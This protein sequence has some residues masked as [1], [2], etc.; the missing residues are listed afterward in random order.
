[1]IV[2]KAK[3]LQDGWVCG[4][5]NG[6]IYDSTDS[7]WFDGQT[8]RWQF[9]ELFVPN[10]NGDGPFATIADNLGSHFSEEVIELCSKKTYTL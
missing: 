3:F 4:G 2:H 5:P 1:M 9:K 7:G 8:L 6:V 10:L